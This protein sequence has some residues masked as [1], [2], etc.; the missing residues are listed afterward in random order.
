[1]SFEEYV[2]KSLAYDNGATDAIELGIDEWCL[3]TMRIGRYVEFLMPFFDAFPRCNIRVMFFE[4]LEND[5]R[6]FMRDLSGFLQIDTAIW[7][8]YPFERENVTFSVSNKGLHRLAMFVNSKGERFLR[9]R[10]QLKRALADLY[11]RANRAQDGIRSHAWAAC[12]ASF[13][14]IICPATKHCAAC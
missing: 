9:R 4:Q 1:M 7:D 5:V 11:R 10:P 14:A 13:M 8:R 12:A 3:K 2:D 6:Q